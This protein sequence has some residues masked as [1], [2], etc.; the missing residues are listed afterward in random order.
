M[1]EAFDRE[2]RAADRVQRGLDM[3]VQG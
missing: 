1:R 3:P 2:Q